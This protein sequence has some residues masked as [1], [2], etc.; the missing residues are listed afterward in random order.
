MGKKYNIIL[1]D[2][3]WSY[4]DRALAGNRGAECKYP[5]M[6]DEDIK[7]LP[8][9]T[10]AADN[11]ILFLWATFPR[12]E[13]ALEVIKSWGFTY[14]TIGF[15]FVKMNKKQTNTLFMGLGNWTR[16][17]SE[18]C[19]IATKGK[20]KRISKSVHS[21]IMAPLERHSAKPKEVHKRIV[22]LMGDLPRIE[23]FA[24]ECFT[25]WTCVG[26][27]IDGLD[28]RDALNNIINFQHETLSQNYD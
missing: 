15:N 24:R 18:I 11:C 6:T 9:K 27:D 12:L 22:E 4:N 25:G 13:L 8:V 26:K 3:A 7:N 21:V 16:S 19:L 14:K 23:L 2:P 17:N 28:V 20:P 10:I 5:V 1:A